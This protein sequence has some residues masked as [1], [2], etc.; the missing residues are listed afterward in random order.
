MVLSL[1]EQKNTAGLRA[2]L[3][4]L[5]SKIFREEADLQFLALMKKSVDKFG[6]S[7]NYKNPDQSP[8]LD[9]IYKSLSD[10]FS[11]NRIDDDLREE[12]AADYASLFLGTG[13][14]PAHPYESVHTSEDG[15]IMRESWNDVLQI[16]GEYGL[17]K[18]G[19]F[20]QP[21]DH[22]AI[23][24]EFMAYLC[25]ETQKAIDME[26]SKNIKVMIKAQKNFIKKHLVSWVP[27]FCND[28]INGSTKFTFYGSV[29]KI[30]KKFILMEGSALKR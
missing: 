21:E 23:E 25:M 8:D 27:N 4:S 1:E 3:Y 7:D 22:I 30:V 19:H 14:H 11:E 29:A 2:G 6:C 9:D 10:F 28:I 18:E 16:Y 15:I 17:K 24:L 5:F 12:L 13:K 20:T 26:D